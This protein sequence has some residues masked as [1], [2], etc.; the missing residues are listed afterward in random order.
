MKFK[1]VK[2][3]ELNPETEVI[4]STDGKDMKDSFY[5]IINL[6]KPHGSEVYEV[7]KRHGYNIPEAETFLLN[8]SIGVTK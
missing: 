5:L 6:E 3:G 2:A 7:L 8:K 1:R 4:T